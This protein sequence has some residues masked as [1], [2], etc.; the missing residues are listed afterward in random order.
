MR[1]YFIYER[2]IEHSPRHY[3]QLVVQHPSVLKFKLET[4]DHFEELE[5]VEKQ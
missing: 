3:L 5:I 2:K 4:H 1:D